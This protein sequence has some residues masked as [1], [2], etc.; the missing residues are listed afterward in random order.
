M[1]IFLF[2]FGLSLGKQRLKQQML[3]SPTSSETHRRDGREQPSPCQE[4]RTGAGQAFSGSGRDD[5]VSRAVCRRGWDG[6]ASTEP[7]VSSR[8][9]GPYVSK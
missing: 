9:C 7:S 1:E 2:P 4:R 8:V 3:N 6:W 5:A